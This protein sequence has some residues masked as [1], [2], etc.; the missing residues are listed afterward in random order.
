[1]NARSGSTTREETFAS[2]RWAG[3]PISDMT[4]EEWAASGWA[5]HRDDVYRWIE[6]GSIV[7]R[8]AEWRECRFDRDY[9]R[10]LSQSDSVDP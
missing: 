8:V 2:E 5:K 9:A 1:M 4:S 7:R 10:W 3:V 6:E